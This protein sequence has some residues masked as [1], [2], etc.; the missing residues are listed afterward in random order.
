MHSRSVGWSAHLLDLGWQW[1]SPDEHHLAGASRRGHAWW[2]QGRRGLLVIWEDKENQETIPGISLIACP[3]QDLAA[4]L[5]DYRR[6]AW[7][8]GYQHVLWNAPLHS[9]LL[10]ILSESGFKRD[11]DESMYIYARRHPDFHD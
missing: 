10:L 8:Y 11:W 4:L 2:W 7:K 1:T 3:V 5:L 6:L 9:E